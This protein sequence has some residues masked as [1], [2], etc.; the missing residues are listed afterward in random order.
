[1]I[2]YYDLSYMDSEYLDFA[3]SECR[4]TKCTSFWIL[5]D[6]KEIV[7]ISDATYIAFDNGTKSIFNSENTKTKSFYPVNLN[8]NKYKT[9]LLF[10]RGIY[11]ISV[12]EITEHPEYLDICDRKHLQKYDMSN[13]Y[14]KIFG[15]RMAD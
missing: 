5:T 3:I 6:E 13:E 11:G 12:S 14:Q 15:R 1:M 10:V 2:S 7:D 8:N 4:E 9:N